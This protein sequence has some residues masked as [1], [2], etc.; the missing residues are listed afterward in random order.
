MPKSTGDSKGVREFGPRELFDFVKFHLG[1]VNR[2]KAK[3]HAY[4][5]KGNGLVLSTV[6]MDDVLTLTGGEPS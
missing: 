2:E 6:E 4:K 1:I 5:I 3:L